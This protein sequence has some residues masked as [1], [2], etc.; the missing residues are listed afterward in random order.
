[1]KQDF[2]RSGLE[3]DYARNSMFVHQKVASHEQHHDHGKMQPA[4][5]QQINVWT[6]TF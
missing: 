6:L 5:P 1:M 2:V 3:S 4:I